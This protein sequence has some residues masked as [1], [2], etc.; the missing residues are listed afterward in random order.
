M[1]S[2]ILLTKNKHCLTS[3]KAWLQSLALFFAFAL[4]N[5]S[6]QR[7]LHY[8]PCLYFWHQRLLLLLC[9]HAR[10]G[11]WGLKYRGTLTPWYP[12]ILIPWY[13]DT[14]DAISRVLLPQKPPLF[15]CESKYW[16]PSVAPYPV[17]VTRDRDHHYHSADAAMRWSSAFHKRDNSLKVDV[18]SPRDDNLSTSKNHGRDGH[19]QN[20]GHGHVMSTYIATVTVKVSRSR[21]R[22]RS[23]SQLM[24]PIY[25][26]HGAYLKSYYA[27][28]IH[29]AYAKSY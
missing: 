15:I 24:E 16:G 27:P 5:V 14:L 21:S 29:G 12:D 25:R 13:L 4:I 11:T 8:S 17:T 26:V 9:L 2:C 23:R 10:E 7:N 6:L 28:L 22:S 20:Y 18:V 1:R 3:C 19:G